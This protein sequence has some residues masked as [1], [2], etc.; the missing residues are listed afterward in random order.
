MENTPE[1]QALEHWYQQL[2]EAN[3][4]LLQVITGFSGRF[5][6]RWLETWQDQGVE[7]LTLL[8][9]DENWCLYET[10]TGFCDLSQSPQYRYFKKQLRAEARI[11]ILQQ[12]TRFLETLTH[13]GR[14]PYPETE[15]ELRLALA[16]LGK[17][18]IQLGNL[19]IAICDSSRALE[20]Y[21]HYA[22]VLEPHA[23]FP[24]VAL[25][26]LGLATSGHWLSYRIAK[27]TGSPEIYQ[28]LSEKARAIESLTYELVIETLR[29]NHLEL[30]SQR[31]A[32]NDETI[33]QLL[34][35]FTHLEARSRQRQLVSAFLIPLLA[36]RGDPIA[37]VDIYEKTLPPTDSL[38]NSLFPLL[39]LGTVASSYSLIGKPTVGMGLVS[40]VIREAEKQGY[41]GIVNQCNANMAYLYYASKKYD[42]AQASAFRAQEHGG[43]FED[44]VSHTL[45]RSVLALSA[46]KQNRENEAQGWLHGLP[47]MALKTACLSYPDLFFDLFLE[48]EHKHV[49]LHPKWDLLKFCNILAQHNS[50]A[51]QTLYSFYEIVR[52]SSHDPYFWPDQKALDFLVQRLQKARLSLPLGNLTL[53]LAKRAEKQGRTE[54]LYHFGK[55]AYTYLAGLSADIFPPE[56][57][58]WVRSEDKSTQ[59]VS[60]ILEIS[61][62]ISS[63]RSLEDLYSGIVDLLGTLTLSERR[64]LFLQDETGT[65]RL[66]AARNFSEKMSASVMKWIQKVTKQKTGLVSHGSAK[67]PISRLCVPLL[68]HDQVIGV[69][70]EEHQ[71]I[72]NA[73]TKQDLEILRTFGMQLAVTIDNVQAHA[74]LE[75]M[76]QRLHKENLY[77]HDFQ[78]REIQGHGIIGKSPAIQAVLE[79]VSQVAHLDTS[80]LVTG[81]TGVGKELVSACIHYSSPRRDGAF[82]IANCGALAGTLI[83]SEFF[84][85]EKGAFTGADNRKIGLFELADQGTLFLDEIG[86]LPLEL[87][88]KLLRVLQNREFQRVGGYKT[89]KSDFRLVAATNRNLREEVHLGKFRRDLYYRL[90][91]F[92]LEV[93]PL[94][95]RKEDIPLL[96]QHF[97]REYSQT[98]GRP[99]ERFES[100][101]LQK[102]MNYGW[103]G[104]VRELRHV[105][106]R[107]VI[108][109][110]NGSLVIEALSAEPQSTDATP[111]VILGPLSSLEEM[112]RQHILRALEHCNGQ[113]H[114]HGGAAEILQIN[115]N[116][117][118]SKMAKLGILTKKIATVAPF[119]G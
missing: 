24:N 112:T 4:Q 36:M 50:Q 80:V 90:N 87:Q 103:P 38:P 70:Y 106:E 59:L 49:R 116:T 19:C 77:Y 47:N 23:Y 27:P 11:A 2:S 10:P 63:F 22:N 30:T 7:L 88:S 32:I 108:L 43:I 41:P 54:D 60:S 74:Q 68:L 64:A 83:E 81:E 76:T 35:K 44:M 25:S 92:P 75:A 17:A 20:T 45:Y 98:V 105:I 72:P 1:S 6:I 37:V 31:D 69:I 56:W 111:E 26:Y 48:A 53:W 67:E 82:I 33:Q 102:L 40:A 28:R 14:A 15:A 8:R 78:Q 57:K 42:E 66:K 86:E 39:Y 91:V 109:S 18:A 65:M 73:F 61:R 107:A 95:E 71:L 93:P 34:R 118:R 79:Q 104:N 97:L 9:S 16:V 114:G 3:Q 99:M 13:S 94:R 115:P 110:R 89:I 58:D 55:L 5:H 51:H 100:S 85:H 52:K 29:V 96:A 101:E 119:G 62:T 84:G 46:L 113:I 12:S 117:L 21:Q